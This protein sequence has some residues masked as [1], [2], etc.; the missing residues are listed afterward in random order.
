MSKQSNDLQSRLGKVGGQAVIEGVMMKSGEDMA[1]ATRMPDRSIKITKQKFVS[2][3]KKHKFLNIPLLRGVINFVEMMI[4]SY[5][6]L[7]VS[8]DAL[9]LEEEEPSKFEKW[10]EKVFGKSIMAVIM[11]ISTILGL[12]LSVFLFIFL[13]S[14]CCDGLGMLLSWITD[15][16]FDLEDSKVLFSA[17]EGILK[18]VI[19]L[20]YL[21]LIS[22]M[23]DIK[24]TFQYHGAEHKSVFCYEKGL[25]L[26]VENVRLQSRYHPRCGTSFMFFM[27]LIGIIIGLFIPT[28][29]DLLRPVIKLLLLP[30]NVGVGFEFIMFAGKHDNLFTK[31]ISKPGLWVQRLTTKE[32]DDGQI[33]CAIAALKNALP[34]EF[35][36]VNEP[37]SVTDTEES[38]E[39]TNGNGDS[40]E[41]SD[42][43]GETANGLSEAVSTDA[44][45]VQ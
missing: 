34:A 13:P 41:N 12:A 24:R 15:G 21:F 28:D 2:V 40:N 8:T 9:G 23:S 14:V 37:I 19:F 11:V 36:E 39:D 22:F 31:I 45:A 5:K 3:R 38:T 25:D 35:P 42:S 4:L 32:P 29:L 27:I 44:D 20:L 1:I 16:S 10:L 6:T 7:S 43:N 18:I 30:I 17:L 26:T 33:E